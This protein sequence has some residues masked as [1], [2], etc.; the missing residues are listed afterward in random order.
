MGDCGGKAAA[1]EDHRRTGK[2]IFHQRL[3]QG[4]NSTPAGIKKPDSGRG[5]AIHSLL[6]YLLRTL[7][8]TEY[9]ALLFFCHRKLL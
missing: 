6:N 5:A 2:G 9:P 4:Y 8:F 3:S 1:D 7:L